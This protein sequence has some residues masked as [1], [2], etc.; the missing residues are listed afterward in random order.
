MR[1]NLT[2]LVLVALCGACARTEDD[3]GPP[4]GDDHQA[5]IRDQRTP[6]PKKHMGFEYD[7]E[8]TYKFAAPVR[9]EF[10]K[11]LFQ[12]VVPGK[13]QGFGIVRGW[14]V[15]F[16]VTEKYVGM[17]EYPE[18]KY[19]AF[20]RDAKLRGI[21]RENPMNRGFFDK[22]IVSSVD[23]EWQAGRKSGER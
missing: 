20:F 8:P 14:S 12:E 10:P 16:W 11:H 5:A 9:C 17:A 15:D 21:F 1:N 23:L 7:G 2:A 22:W 6:D 13:P 19:T 4:P 18:A 3:G